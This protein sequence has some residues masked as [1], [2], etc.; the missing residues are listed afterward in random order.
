MRKFITSALPV[1][2]LLFIISC[3]HEEN[4]SPVQG[5]V[6][7]SF[8]QAAISDGGRTKGTATA[9]FVLFSL[10]D[11]KGHVQENIILPLYDFGQGHITENLA[12]QTGNYQLTQFQ[13]LDAANKIIYASPLEG[14]DLAKYVI[15]PLPLDFT[16]KNEATQITPQV[17]AVVEDNP[18]A[19]KVNLN[20]HL[21]YPDLISFD[22]AYVTFKNTTTEVKVKLTLD[23]V[24]HVATGH[25]TDLPCGDWTVSASYFSTEATTNK[26]L[27]K[28][29]VVILQITPTATDLISSE[30]FVFIEE[31]AYPVNL[32]SFKWSA[33][34]YYQLF[35]GDKIEGI[36]RLPKDPTDPYFEILTFQPK[37][38]YVFTT[39]LFYDRSFDG[40]S[41]YYQGGSAFEVYGENG[42]SHDCLEQH[43][44]NTT[45]LAPGILNVK[46][47]PWNFVTGYIVMYDYV[48]NEI[49]LF[50]GWDL[51]PPGGE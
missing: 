22:S 11:G 28:K 20:I 2:L 17:L 23:N 32:K 40:N 12:L 18:P 31:D 26:S 8:S 25:I 47:K 43:I 49:F 4:L 44:I 7:F 33:Y 1:F 41:N 36:M 16:I 19:T 51:R 15:D 13:V 6:T 46:D 50:Y 34:Y 48:G 9:A 42:E 29:G 35:L 30:G 21:Q 3:Q 10:K 27:E 38:V 39:R 5:K 37:W 45:S 24:S 14:S